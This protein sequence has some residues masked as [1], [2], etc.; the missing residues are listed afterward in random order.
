[1]I[2]DCT[3]HGISRFFKV[4]L[5]LTTP[6]FVLKQVPTLWRQMRRG[7]GAV[8]VVVEENVVTVRYSDFPYFGDRRYRLLTEGTLRGLIRVA[9]K[10]KAVL[11]ISDFG[12][13]WLD[14]RIIMP[15]G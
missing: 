4:L 3:E 7:C 6:Q 9:T 14:V 5:R 2:E 15:A 8:D 10:R 11:R 12:A 13:D 1:M